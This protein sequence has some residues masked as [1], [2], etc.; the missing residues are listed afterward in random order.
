MSLLIYVIIQPYH[1][2]SQVQNK[3]M[4][5]IICSKIVLQ[6]LAIHLGDMLRVAWSA[7]L[8]RSSVFL[9]NQELQ[10]KLC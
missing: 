10:Q 1:Y 9:Q 3:Q 8:R 5:I 7:L 6:A 2:S 4:C